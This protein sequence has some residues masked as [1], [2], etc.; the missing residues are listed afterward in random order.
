MIDPAA[1][2]P[3]IGCRPLDLAGDIASVATLF[4]AGAVGWQIVCPLDAYAGAVGS[5]PVSMTETGLAILLG[6]A[7]AA[8]AMIGALLALIAVAIRCAAPIEADEDYDFDAADR[9]R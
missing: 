9:S 6:L 4:F 7:V 1:P 8:G 5:A 3:A 2:S